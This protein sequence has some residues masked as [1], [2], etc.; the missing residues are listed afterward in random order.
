MKGYSKDTNRKIRKT[1]FIYIC[2]SNIGFSSS[3]VYT[4]E[5]W[6]AQNGTLYMSSRNLDKHN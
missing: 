1:E 6:A 4:G 2:S 3:A 5:V